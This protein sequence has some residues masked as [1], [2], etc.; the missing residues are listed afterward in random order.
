MRELGSPQATRE[1]EK[2]PTAP[3][4][5]CAV[6]VATSSFS[7][8]S[9]V[10]FAELSRAVPR[11]TCPAATGRSLMEVVMAAPETETMGPQMSSAVSM[12]WLPTSPRAP[13]PMGPL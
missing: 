5:K 13:E 9:Y 6:K 4:A 10:A 11:V 7:T 2:V 8:G 1:Q 3:L 12:R